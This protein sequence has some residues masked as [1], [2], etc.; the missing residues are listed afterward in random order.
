MDHRNFVNLCHRNLEQGEKFPCH[1]LGNLLLVLEV[2][3]AE[4]DP[5]PGTSAG[6]EALPYLGNKPSLIVYPHWKDTKGEINE[7]TPGVLDLDTDFPDELKDLDLEAFDLSNNTNG[8][9]EIVG[10]GLAALQGY[11]S[12]VSADHTS[13]LL[14][15]DSFGMGEH[16]R[17]PN[18]SKLDP[19]DLLDFEPAEDSGKEEE[20][21]EEKVEVAQEEKKEML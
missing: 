8:L 18:L 15:E 17:D 4:K 21:K 11:P 5:Q 12:E 14:T 16:I 6:A 9:L 13:E 7:P 20:K 10:D 3:E 1:G 2:A 19:E